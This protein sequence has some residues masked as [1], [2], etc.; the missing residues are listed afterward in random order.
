MT[1]RG[2][3]PALV[4][5]LFGRGPEGNPVGPELDPH[6]HIFENYN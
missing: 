2:P 3:T 5:H 1:G 4:F 6:W